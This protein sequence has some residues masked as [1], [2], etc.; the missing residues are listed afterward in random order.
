VVKIDNCKVQKTTFAIG[1]ESK[2]WEGHPT[3]A[4]AVQVLVRAFRQEASK[5]ES[6]LCRF[7]HFDFDP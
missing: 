7:A 1:Q 6:G 4:F 3:F 5:I 2:R